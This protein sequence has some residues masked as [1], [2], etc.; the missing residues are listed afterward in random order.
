MRVCRG[1]DAAGLEKA[2]DRGRQVSH[3]QVD[4]GLDD[5]SR[6]LRR[7]R[8]AVLREGISTWVGVATWDT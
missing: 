6:L 7:R 1:A 2:T 4:A 8:E 5:Q 3:D